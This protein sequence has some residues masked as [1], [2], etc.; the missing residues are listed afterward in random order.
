MVTPD[1]IAEE[2]QRLRRLRTIVDLTTAVLYQRDLST[3]EALE[4]VRAT[5]KSVL[6]LFPGQGRTFDLIY[7]ARFERIIRE[8]LKSN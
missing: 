7:K 8:R 1:E 5:K 3:T 2:R 4:L 6:R